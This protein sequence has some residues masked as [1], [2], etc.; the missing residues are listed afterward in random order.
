MGGIEPPTIGIWVRGSN[1]LSYTGT[2]KR[3]NHYRK[4]NRTST[5]ASTAGGLYGISGVTKPQLWL[6]SKLSLTRPGWICTIVLHIISITLSYWATGIYGGA[7]GNRTPISWET[8]RYNGHYTIAPNAPYGARVAEIYWLEFVCLIRR[9]LLCL[10][11]MLKKSLATKP[12]IYNP[13]DSSIYWFV[14]R[15]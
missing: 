6:A 9:Y 10:L 15:W 11:F 12:H 7:T 3:F 1:L 13:L 5:P 2:K 14:C 8:V 4:G